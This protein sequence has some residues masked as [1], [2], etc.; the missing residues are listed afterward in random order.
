MAH[1]L[2]D[3]VSMQSVYKYLQIFANVPFGTLDELIDDVRHKREKGLSAHKWTVGRGLICEGL[4]FMHL[5]L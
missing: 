3:G 2:I 4:T 1:V 5:L